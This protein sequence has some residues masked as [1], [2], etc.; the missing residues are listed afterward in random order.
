M[1]ENQNPESPSAESAEVIKPT[2]EELE[3][4]YANSQEAVKLGLAQLALSNAK[5]RV[6]QEKIDSVGEWIDE[7]LGNLTPRQ[8]EELCDLLGLD[9]EITKTITV[10]AS[11]EVEITA[12]RS[13]DFDDINTYDFSVSLEQ[14]SGAEWS[15]FTYNSDITD[16]S[17]ED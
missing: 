13:F 9:S 12:P 7:E 16:I 11:F 3:T 4:L 6:A 5:A 10:E 17:V 1:W 8:V 2:Y 15:V 14:S